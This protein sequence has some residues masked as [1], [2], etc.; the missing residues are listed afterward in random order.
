MT[1]IVT[2]IPSKKEL[3]TRLLLGG[4]V[5]IEDPAL[6]PEW[7]PYGASFLAADLPVGASIVVTNHP[8]R[9]WFANIKRTADGFKVT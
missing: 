6:M 4:N 8:K 9:T 7:R 5:R 2:A 1:M 3:K